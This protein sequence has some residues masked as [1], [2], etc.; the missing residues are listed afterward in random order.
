MNS[1]EIARPVWRWPKR[2]VDLQHPCPRSGRAGVSVATS[3]NQAV[4]SDSNGLASNS[5][6]GVATPKRRVPRTSA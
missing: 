2:V 1:R 4:P 5:R 6:N 3:K